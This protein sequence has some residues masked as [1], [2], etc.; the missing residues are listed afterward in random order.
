MAL[1]MEKLRRES[2]AERAK[3]IEY[4]DAVIKANDMEFEYDLIGQF[5]GKILK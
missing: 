4:N 2:L 1:G 3:M 5:P